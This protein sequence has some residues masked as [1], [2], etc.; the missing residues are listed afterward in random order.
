MWKY[1]LE[2]GCFL[3]W[4]N[5]QLSGD[6]I[7]KIWAT[8]IPTMRLFNFGLNRK[9]H[10]KR[11]NAAQRNKWFFPIMTCFIW[12]AVTGIFWAKILGACRFPLG[13]TCTTRSIIHCPVVLWWE[14]SCVFGPNWPTSTTCSPKYGAE[15]RPL[16]N[17][18]GTKHPRLSQ[19]RN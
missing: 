6:T 11:R 19:K 14:A 17:G 4:N 8:N 9:M 18:C 15:E 5:S 2:N 3:K 7:S 16:L 12:I 10:R 13:A 1:S